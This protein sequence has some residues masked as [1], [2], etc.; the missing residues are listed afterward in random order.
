MSL[1]RRVR[2]GGGSWDVQGQREKGIVSPEASQTGWTSSPLAMW[3]K[4]EKHETLF[5]ELSLYTAIFEHVYIA[6]VTYPRQSSR[7]Y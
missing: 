5:A 7:C 2:D 3:Q 1:V 6:E 4:S